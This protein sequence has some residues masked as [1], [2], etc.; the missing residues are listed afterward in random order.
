MENLRDHLSRILP[1]AIIFA[2]II[3]ILTLSERPRCQQCG[4]GTPS[5]KSLCSGECRE[6]WD[7]TH[8]KDS[9]V[10]VK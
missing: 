6:A 10:Q 2:G 7:R 8:R 5:W 9:I 3:A 1:H 4:G